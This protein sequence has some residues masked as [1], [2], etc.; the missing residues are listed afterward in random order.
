MSDAGYKPASRHGTRA[1]V[2][3]ELRAERSGPPKV[4]VWAVLLALLVALIVG[5]MVVTDKD[6]VPPSDYRAPQTAP[7]GGTAPAPQPEPQTRQ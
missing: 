2:P 1:P 6:E 3:D 5:W 7:N 4:T